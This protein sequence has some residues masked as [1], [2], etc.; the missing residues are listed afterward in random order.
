MVISFD[1]GVVLCC[2]DMSRQTMLGSIPDMSVYDVWNGAGFM[3]MLERL[4]LL[5]PSDE[6]L[7]CDKCELAQQQYSSGKIMRYSPKRVIKKLLPR[8]VAEYL[9]KTNYQWSY[10]WELVEAKIRETLSRNRLKG[11]QE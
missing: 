3:D 5:K 9:Q 6:P 8:V 7:I 11:R 2:Q 10:K 4:Y 1:G